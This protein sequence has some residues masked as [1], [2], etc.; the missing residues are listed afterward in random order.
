MAASSLRSTLMCSKEHA[1]QHSA[2]QWM[3]AC[4]QTHP[5]QFRPLTIIFASS[6][7][8]VA[9]VSMSS[10][11]QAAGNMVPSLENPD[12]L[13]RVLNILGPGQHLLISAVSK[14]WRDSYERVDSVQIVGDPQGY[15]ELEI[16]LTITSQMTLYSSIFASATAVKWA[17]EC[18]LPFD[19]AKLQ[20]IAG[21]VADIPVLYAA[22][23]LGLALT[24]EVFVGAAA[25]ASIA[26]L[27]LLHSEQGCRLSSNICGWA[28]RSGSID[29]LRWAREHGGI[30]TIET[31]GGA[32]AGAH[33]HVLQYL[34]DEGCEWDEIACAVAAAN[35]QLSTLK[36]LH[37]HGCPWHHDYI[38][39]DAAESGSIETLLYLRQE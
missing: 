23:A 14:A 11:N 36:W 18:G 24:D 27:Q 10:T 4:A 35:D 28:A 12:I 9:T 2:W 39:S 5:A 25:A 3:E 20:R 16:L 34:S 19:N 37:E 38:C 7:A 33:L 30:C 6:K 32:A 13:L 22:H 21:R 31:P 29:A 17:H 15:D 8:A 1:G 26:K